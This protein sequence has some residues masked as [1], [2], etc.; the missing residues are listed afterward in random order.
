[1]WSLRNILSL[2]E[3][4]VVTCF[5]VG[6]LLIDAG[7]GVG[8][9]GTRFAGK[10]HLPMAGL[11]WSAPHDLMPRT[12]SKTPALQ[13]LTNKSV[14]ENCEPKKN[15]NYLEVSAWTDNFNISSDGSISTSAPRSWRGNRSSF[16][17][18]RNV[19]FQVAQSFKAKM[20]LRSK[21][22]EQGFRMLWCLW[23]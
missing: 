19:G 2:K 14:E 8:Q 17:N 16:A 21:K 13:N 7:G 12:S 6:I 11:K 5:A 1:M 18:A 3:T 20:N 9:I 22:F 10:S 15:I 23:I 4:G